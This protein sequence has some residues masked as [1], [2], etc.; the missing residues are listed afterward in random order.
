MKTVYAKVAAIGMD[1]HAKFTTVAMRDADGKVVRRERLDHA[2]R[3][4]LREH[5]AGWPAEASVVLEASFG[6]MWLAELMDEAGLSPQLSNCYKLHQL[7]KARGWVKTN[8]K[9]AD[10]LSLLPFETDRWWQVW[11]APPAVRD[12]RE[13]MRYRA[14]LVAVQTATKQRITALLHRFG[15]LHRFSDVFGVG[16]RRWLRVI[17][18]AE[19]TEQAPLSTGAVAALRGHLALL[20]HV[21]S[22]LAAITRALRA[23]LPCS[24]LADRLATIPGVGLILAHV[25]IA[26]IGRIERFR[27]HRALASYSLLAPLAD[28]SGEQDATTAPLGRHLGHRGNRTLKWT[29]IEAAHAAIRHGGQWRRRFEAA[30]DGGRRDRNRGYI[31]VARELVKIVYVVWSRGMAYTETPPPRPGR[32]ARRQARCPRTDPRSRTGQPFSPMAAV[33]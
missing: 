6:W 17:V 23:E 3:S 12:R 31:N 16:G 5:L 11:L 20:D 10:L 29:F 14:S 33:R 4:A 27:H 1:V 24:E 18:A 9:D 13:W 22:E 28:E 32:S 15:I 26:E 30:T 19:G 25:L 21:R 7:R 8:K 2:D